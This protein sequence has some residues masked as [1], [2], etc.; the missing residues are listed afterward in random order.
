MQANLIGLAKTKYEKETH[1]KNENLILNL[2]ITNI[3]FDF[4]IKI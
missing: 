2:R 1:K 4:R 3:F